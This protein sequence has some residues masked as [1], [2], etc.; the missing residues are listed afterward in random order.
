MAAAAKWAAVWAA[1]RWQPEDFDNRIGDNLEK[2]RLEWRGADLRPLLRVS[3]WGYRPMT[4]SLRIFRSKSCP[5]MVLGP[6]TDR[7]TPWNQ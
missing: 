2:T 6:I 3:Q 5:H 7:R 4:G 1:P